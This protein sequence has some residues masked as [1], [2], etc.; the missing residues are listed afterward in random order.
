MSPRRGLGGFPN[1][2][3]DRGK[4]FEDDLQVKSQGFLTGI[5]YIQIHHFIESGFVLSIDLPQTC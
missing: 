5:S 2:P 3:E 4:R 1:L